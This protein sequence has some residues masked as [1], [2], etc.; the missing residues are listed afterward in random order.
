MSGTT[1]N[2]VPD[3]DW[4]AEMRALEED[5]RLAFL[6]RDTQRLDR[7]WSQEYVVNS[8]MNVAIGKPK[9]LE[10]LRNGRIAHI[11][12]VGAIEHMSRYGDTIVVMGRETVVNEPGGQ[13]IER[14]YTNVWRLEDG[15]WKGIA[16]HANIVAGP[17]AAQAPPD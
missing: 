3:P 12:C 7:I 11:S 13:P 5:A 15:E 9:V 4:Q 2:G 6:A 16:R 1:G 14:R 17:P 8:P 10:L